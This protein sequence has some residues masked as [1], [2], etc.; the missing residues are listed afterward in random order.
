[1]ERGQRRTVTG[2]S[3]EGAA[4][5]GEG[6]LEA[7]RESRAGHAGALARTQLCLWLG[8]PCSVTSSEQAEELQPQEKGLTEVLGASVQ[9]CLLSLAELISR[10]LGLPLL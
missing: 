2:S 7:S 3:L 5:P 6:E 4:E 1:M 9:A 8:S 10:F